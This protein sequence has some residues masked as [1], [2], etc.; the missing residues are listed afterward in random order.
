MGLD[1]IVVLI[2]A[3]AF[4]GGLAYILRKGRQ[5]EQIEDQAVPPVTPDPVE[6]TPPKKPRKK[7]QKSSKR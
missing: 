6:S 4:F 1:K 3:L 7:N 5:N 2:M